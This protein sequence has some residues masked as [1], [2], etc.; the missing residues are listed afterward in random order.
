M[1]RVFSKWICPHCQ[2]SSKDAHIQAIHDY[3]FLISSTISNKQCRDF[4]HLA[5][6]M[7]AYRLLSEMNLPHNG[8]TKGRIYFSPFI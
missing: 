1:K 4:L 7:T 3:F 5:S 8:I 6:E 2:S